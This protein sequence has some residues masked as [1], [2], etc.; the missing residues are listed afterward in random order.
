MRIDDDVTIVVEKEALINT[1]KQNRETHITEYE[2]ALAG[3]RTKMT[4]ACMETSQK[5]DKGELKDFP[6]ALSKL[7]DVPDSHVKDYDR[8]IQMLEMDTQDKITLN[9]QDFSRY[10]QDEWAWK[11]RFD[12]SNSAYR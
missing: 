10:V 11:E 2:E 12:L 8:V 4:A 3:W 5:A 6:R 9:A 1:L 7:N